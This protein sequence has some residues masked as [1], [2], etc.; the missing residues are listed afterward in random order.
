[1]PYAPPAHLPRCG[2]VDLGSITGTV[3]TLPGQQPVR[4]R[5]H[6]PFTIVPG[7]MISVADEVS[8]RFDPPP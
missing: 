4:L 8:A 7:T 2:V 3:V 1:M 6:D 5:A